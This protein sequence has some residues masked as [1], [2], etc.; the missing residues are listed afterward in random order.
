MNELIAFVKARLD[1]DEADAKPWQE[2]IALFA[3]E[4]FH[5]PSRVLCEVA[6]GRR[7]LA[8]CLKLR[9]HRYDS[10]E[11]EGRAWLA[12]EMIAYLAISWSG[13]ADYRQKWAPKPMEA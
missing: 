1:E 11:D 6:A 9:E 8:R 10:A 12:N 13:H 2:W 4:G 7:I 5:N 3:A